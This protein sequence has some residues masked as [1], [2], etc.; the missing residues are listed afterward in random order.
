MK[1]APYHRV[2]IQLFRCIEVSIIPSRDI[3]AWSYKLSLY[4]VLGFWQ[5]Q[6]KFVY[7][8]P[9]SRF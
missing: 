6:Q 2:R 9:S 4:V 5:I 7:F 3:V 1:R 8:A